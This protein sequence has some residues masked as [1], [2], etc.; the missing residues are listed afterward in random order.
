MC[1]L[2]GV[3]GYA[4]YDKDLIE[5]VRQLAV[6]SQLRGWDSTGV[7]KI[8]HNKKLYTIVKSPVCASD[9]IDN[10][11]ADSVLRDVNSA[12]V[13]IGHTRAATRGAVNKANC[14]PFYEEGAYGSIVLAH[15]GFA[16]GYNSKDYNVDS[17]WVCAMIA[18]EGPDFLKRLRGEYALTWYDFTRDSLF[19][20]RNSKRPLF[21]ADVTAGTATKKVWASE[22]WMLS[23]LTRNG[24]R[25]KALYETS[26]HVLYEIDPA[27]SRLKAAT[28]YE[29]PVVVVPSYPAAV[30]SDWSYGA[31]YRSPLPLAKPED[32]GGREK[33]PTLPPPTRVGNMYRQGA[34]CPIPAST[35][36]DAHCK[37]EKDVR[38]T[39]RAKFVK[40]NVLGDDK[41]NQVFYTMK[42][43]P[44]DELYGTVPQVTVN[45]INHGTEWMSGQ[46]LKE[47]GWVTLDILG[48][49]WV[50][51]PAQRKLVTLHCMVPLAPWTAIMKPTTKNVPVVVKPVVKLDDDA[52]PHPGW[53]AEE[54]AVWNKIRDDELES[55]YA[56]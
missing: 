17:Q 13:L 46:I 14:H 52:P 56:A 18:E 16:E 40:L 50:G 35:A 22:K 45:A 8:D 28:A 21:V 48:A 29:P 5:S 54:V 43:D 32:V 3:V 23:A 9:F 2:W 27:N 49:E 38:T 47:D 31:G 42:I 7:A 24:L 1:G 37:T 19:M 25:I 53:T 51:T 55:R 44:A 11:H 33:P 4:G 12:G 6:F 26:P 34:M 15:N 30:R 39:L 20:A 36:W 10:K 41:N